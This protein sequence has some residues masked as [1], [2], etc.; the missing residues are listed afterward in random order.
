MLI[1]DIKWTNISVK[2]LSGDDDPIDKIQELTK[3]IILESTDSGIKGPPYDPFEIG[4]FLGIEIMPKHD[5]SDA[6]TVPLSNDKFLI[7]YNPSK[8]RGRIRFSIAHELSHTLFPDCAREIRNREK[9][10][11]IGHDRWQLEMLCNIGASEF[12]MPIGSFPNLSN[13]DISIGNFLNLRKKYDVSCE[14]LFLRAVKLTEVPCF[15]FCATRVDPNDY[16][17]KYSFD[18]IV[19]S[20][21]WGL[22]LPRNIDLPSNSIVKTCTAVGYKVIGDE[23][24]SRK[25]GSFHVEC[26]GI[27]PYHSHRYPRVLG[28]VTKSKVKKRKINTINYKIGDAAQPQANTPFIIAH[29]VNNK[30]RTW[31]GRGFAKYLKKKLP[32]VEKDFIKWRQNNPGGFELGAIHKFSPDDKSQII[33]MVAQMGYGASIGPRIRYGALKTCLRLVADEALKRSAS[34]HMPRIGCGEAGGSWIIVSELIEDELC[35]KGL[36]VYVYDLPPKHKN[37]NMFDI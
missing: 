16:E 21:S 36:V 9:S 6:R 35:N 7:E 27:P 23:T 22:N 1:S 14:A 25:L 12:L 15:V 34:V 24:W 3:K 19:C 13:T 28:I 8:S 20:K 29:V 5:I 18:Y 4:R 32:I 33:S 37:L 11:T 17:G 2:G 30:A 26:V 10:K 31:G